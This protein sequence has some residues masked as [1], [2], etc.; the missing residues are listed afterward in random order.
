[1]WVAIS[2]FILRNRLTLLI[3]I[4]VLTVFMLYKAKDTELS[5]AG[6]KVLPVSDPAF[7]T[8]LKFK[9]KFGE[10]GSVM[11]IGVNDPK[12][13]QLEFYNDWYDL[14]KEIKAFKGIT[15]VISVSRLFELQKDT[16]N[17]K[18][19]LRNVIE[20]KPK[21]LVEMDSLKNKIYSLELY[22]GFIFNKESGATLMAIT[23]DGKN[24]NS[25]NRIS[26]VNKIYKIAEKLSQKHQV[27]LHYSGLPY[28]RT[29]I[30]KKVSDEFQ[31]F[32]VLAIGITGV[33]LVLFFRSFSAFLVPLVIVVVGVIWSLGTIV[34]LDYK[35]TLLTGLIPPLIV[36][37]GIPNS[38]LLLNKY[39]NEFRIHG[40]KT[41]SLMM[42]IQRIGITTLLANVTT[43]IGF[44]VFYFTNSEVLTEFGI[45]TSINIM[46]TYVSSLVL[47]PIIFS[48]L[49][50][51]SVKQTKHLENV[52]IGRIINFLDVLV[53]TSRQ[54]I[55]A[56]TV[57]I[58]LI[59]MY[60]MY[61]IQVNGYVVDDLPKND[62]I[63]V[64][65]LFFQ[66][67]FKGA[68]PFDISIDSKKKNGI[69][70]L[71]T[72][73]KLEK[74]Q[75]MIASYPEFSKPL[76][77][78]EVIK[79]STQAYYNGNPENYALPS[80]FDQS[81]VFLYAANS[82]GTSNLLRT[83]I[84]SNKQVA[85]V[86]FQMVDVGSK[87]LNKLVK[88][89]EPRI[90][91]IFN[92]EK[93]DV[94]LTGSSIIFLNGNNYLIKNLRESLI[95]AIFLISILMFIL[96]RTFKMIAISLLPNIIPL[97]ITAGIMG[98]FGI[99]LKPSTIL[100]FSIAFGIASDQTIYFLTKYQQEL[101]H[102]SISIAE[103]ISITL[104]ETGVSMIYTA[105]ILFFGFGIF[106]A[107]NFGGTVALG[108]LVSITLL[109]ALVSNLILLPS[110]LLSLN[111]RNRKKMPE[112]FL[113]IDEE[114]DENMILQN[115][116]KPE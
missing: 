54:K 46:A 107:S 105:V 100:I 21:N 23:F 110:L 96:F 41:R 68:L 112:P 81:F 52:S 108:I 7:A 37:I 80:T 4:G 104:R 8:Y 63:Y 53:H 6:S 73:K 114:D 111:L 83:Y 65:L 17:S 24:L 59:S 93:F 78:N 20:S 36:V 115:K 2:K 39:H 90:D 45:V 62:P 101:R 56:V 61:K 9:E 44:G 22:N 33:I 60:G 43:A 55:Y 30:S 35:I 58:V 11:V 103:A 12:N 16:L 10:D 38:I 31:L 86:S 26:E 82:M 91:S 51:P 113:V 18:F 3:V 106:A 98:Y 79:F 87:K 99:S 66:T 94:N 25:K 13:F 42:V 74:L 28:I 109:M 48:Y 47:I 70:N 27:K 72:I 15:E 85:R 14:G 92:P 29:V 116:N 5:Y 32:L 40:D 64:D 67:N 77:I 49:P 75:I 50:S 84:D 89:L 69:V 88:E 19:L 1:M 57:V 95:L 76:S 34:L 97:I 71:P 102:R